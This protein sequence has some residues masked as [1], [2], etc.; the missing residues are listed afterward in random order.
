MKKKSVKTEEKRR[1]GFGTYER[2]Q[3]MKFDKDSTEKF[4]MS[5]FLS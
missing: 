5:N 4:G 2:A 1:V 3:G